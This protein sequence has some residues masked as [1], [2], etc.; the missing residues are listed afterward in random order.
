MFID[1]MQNHKYFLQRKP[2]KRKSLEIGWFFMNREEI[3][4]RVNSPITMPYSHGRFR[5]GT[6][7]SREKISSASML[8]SSR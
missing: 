6:F 3:F 4:E 5:E 1:G 7:F 2:Y 8:P